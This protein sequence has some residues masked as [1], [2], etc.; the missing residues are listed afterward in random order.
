MIEEKIQKAV[1]INEA[2]EVN[3]Q[4]GNTKFTPKLYMQYQ[5]GAS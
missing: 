1:G 2:C 3:S 4:E 5:F